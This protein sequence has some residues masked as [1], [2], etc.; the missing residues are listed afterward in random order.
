MSEFSEL[1]KDLRSE[2]LNDSEMKNRLN[3]IGYPGNTHAYQDYQNAIDDK[4]YA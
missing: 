2:Q 1:K 4:F 3:Q